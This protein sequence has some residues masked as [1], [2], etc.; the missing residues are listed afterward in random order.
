MK[1]RLKFEKT[2]IV[3]Y[4]GHLDLMRFFQKAFRRTSI[5]ISFTEGFNPH[6]IMSFAMPLGVGV[7]S[8][9]E[10]M[11]FSVNS[12]IDIK[13]SMD[14]L[15]AVMCEGIMVTGIYPL[16][17]N[18]KKAMSIIALADYIIKFDDEII[19][20]IDENTWDTLNDKFYKNALEIS[21][22]KK[23]K[24]S[25]KIVDIKPMIKKFRAYTENDEKLLFLS[26]DTGSENNLNPRL[27]VEALYHYLNIEYN[28]FGY[29]IKR[30]ELYAKKDNNYLTL[31]E[32]E[33][34]ATL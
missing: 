31:G 25:E 19:R 22:L 15:N 18:A 17:D 6:Q 11:D 16:I 2:G 29:H 26:L 4:I 32:Y 5:D 30:T 12:P 33:C 14:E 23:T 10:Y 7:E 27:V 1:M 9:G 8:V 21:I 20:N 28:D 34:S 13:K 3:K 24:K